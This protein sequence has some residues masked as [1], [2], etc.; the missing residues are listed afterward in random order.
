VDGTSSD[1]TATTPNQVFAEAGDKFLVR[2]GTKVYLSSSKCSISGALEVV[3]T[4]TSTANDA[5]MVKVGEDFYIAVR[6]GAN[7][8]YRKVS[9]SAVPVSVNITWP[10]SLTPNEHYYALDGRGRLYMITAGDTVSVY[11][12]DGTLAG[13]ASVSSVTFAGLLGLAD[14]ALAKTSSNVYEITIT[15]STVSAVNKG[16]TLHSVVDNCTH[17]NTIAI[18]GAGTNF[19]RCAHSS[20]LYS[21]TYDSGSVLYSQASRTVSISAVKFAT[22]KVLVRSG[23]VIKLCSTTTSSIS[24]SDTDLTDFD[25]TL[26]RDG[27]TDKYL[28]SNGNNVFYRVGTSPTYT[29]KV[30]N[31]FDPPSALITVS[32]ASGGNASL[33]LNKFAFNFKPPGALCATQILYLPSRTASPKY[34]TIAQPSNACVT[35]ILKVY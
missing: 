9:G 10:A 24:C 4:G 28:K 15:G 16:G 5:K 33:D 18:D 1:I 6:A 19:I 17:T 12:I 35:R 34:Y 27:T 20:G 25:T 8:Y 2:K 13:A 31:I 21:L 11:N 26:L 3:D 7:L 22:G 32:D 29:L 30:G 14:R 23:S